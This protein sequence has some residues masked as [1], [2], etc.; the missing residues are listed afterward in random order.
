MPITRSNTSILNYSS[1]LLLNTTR[2]KGLIYAFLSVLNTLS[3]FLVYLKSISF[4][5]STISS[6]IIFKKFYINYLLKLINL[7][8]A[9][10]SF[11]VFSVS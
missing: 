2:T 11:I 8:K 7:K 5:I 9:C 4:F 6:I 3:Y 10:I 1:S